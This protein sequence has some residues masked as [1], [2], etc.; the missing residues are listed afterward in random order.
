MFS[1]F[2]NKESMKQGCITF[3]E[4]LLQKRH[5]YRTSYRKTRLNTS[6]VTCNRCKNLILRANLENHQ[7]S[8]NCIDI[9]QDI[10]S[11]L[12]FHKQLMENKLFQEFLKINNIDF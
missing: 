2:L 3:E 10:R 4:H 11:V 12:D 7:N 6:R 9:Y 1:F 5:E 8:S